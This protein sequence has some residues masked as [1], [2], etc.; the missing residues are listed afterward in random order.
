MRVSFH[1]T[2]IKNEAE[3]KHSFSEVVIYLIVL[4]LFLF[5]IIT[6]EHYT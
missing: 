4:L 1:E 2:K 5:Y 3:N 6:I